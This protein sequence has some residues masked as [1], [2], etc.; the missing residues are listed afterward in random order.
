MPG[1]HGHAHS[2][3][4]APGGVAWVVL[5]AIVCAAAAALFGLLAEMWIRERRARRARAA[6]A[7]MISGA[8]GQGD[9]DPGSPSSGEH[10]G[11][12]A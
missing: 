3:D 9:P 6:Y 2:H 1:E 10:S 5:D 7:E 8:G 11:P 12:E 4:G